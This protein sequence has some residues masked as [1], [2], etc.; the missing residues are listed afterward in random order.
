MTFIGEKF[1]RVAKGQLLVA[2]SII[3]S[4]SLNCAFAC[5]GISAQYKNQYF[6]RKNHDWISK[7]AA[8]VINPRGMLNHDSLY[9]RQ[10]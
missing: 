10:F 8:I 3:I 2:V 9:G 5:T 1:M 7:Y 4:L 6:V